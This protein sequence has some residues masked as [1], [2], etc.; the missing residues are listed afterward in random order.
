MRGDVPFIRIVKHVP[1]EMRDKLPSQYVSLLEPRVSCVRRYL[2][3]D[4]KSWQGLLK[5]E[6]LHKTVQDLILFYHRKFDMLFPPINWPVILFHYV[7]RLALPSTN[8]SNPLIS[9]LF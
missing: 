8:M 2:D 4:T 3:M 5:A 6:H 7:R 9:R 1:R